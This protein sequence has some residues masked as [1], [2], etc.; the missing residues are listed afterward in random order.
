M[1]SL[2]PTL[3][4]KVMMSASET[5]REMGTHV[6]YVHLMEVGSVAAIVA[7]TGLVYLADQFEELFSCIGVYTAA[8]GDLQRSP[9]R[10]SDALSYPRSDARLTLSIHD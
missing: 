6:E 4:E 2:G 8:I 10:L 9:C 1:C 3:Y 5:F 7:C